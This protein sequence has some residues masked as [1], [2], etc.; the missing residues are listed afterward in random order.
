MM[1]TRSELLSAR[2]PYG[3]P[4]RDP[5]AAT[6]RCRISRVTGTLGLRA[7]K[8]MCDPQSRRK[9]VSP[10]YACCSTPSR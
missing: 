6:A 9:P 3:C 7:P 8:K 4:R 1:P 5:A 10:S 2:I